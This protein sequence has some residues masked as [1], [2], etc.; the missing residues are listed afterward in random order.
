M[1]TGGQI[2]IDQLQIQGVK[3]VFCVP[4]R[5]TWRRWMRCTIRRWN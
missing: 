3:H 4:G 1:R 2:L 5:A